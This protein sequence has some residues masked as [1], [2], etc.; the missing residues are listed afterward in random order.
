VEASARMRP[1]CAR[2]V[3]IGTVLALVTWVGIVVWGGARSRPDQPAAV[4]EPNPVTDDA[5]ALLRGGLRPTEVRALL[6]N[7]SRRTVS[8]AEGFAWPEPT[9]VCWYYPS[10]DRLREYQVCF[11][12]WKLVTRGSYAVERGG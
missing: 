12:Q 5:F 1:L 3:A 4:V 8:L 11:I 6:G 7:P 9:D 2:H 10:I